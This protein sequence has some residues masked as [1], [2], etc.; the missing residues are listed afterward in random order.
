M[1]AGAKPGE[2]RGGR[3]K[4]SLNKR[5]VQD[6]AHAE[7]AAKIAAEI[8]IPK[9][10]AEHA[11]QV[12]QRA[13]IGRRLAKDEVEESLIPMAKAVLMHVQTRILM[14]ERDRDGRL[15]LGPDAKPRPV[16]GPDGKQQIDP[17]ADLSEYLRWAEFFSTLLFGVMPYQSARLSAILSLP[18]PQAAVEANGGAEIVRMGNPVAASRAYQQ[19]MQ[20][21]RRLALPPP[22]KR[23]A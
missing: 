12:L 16:F 18:A 2:R 22:A 11:L 15:V 21:P 14:Y 20:A 17:G 5:T 6:L 7:E 10:R 8:G 13:A 4:G 9:E 1:P 23:T 3:Q 19:L